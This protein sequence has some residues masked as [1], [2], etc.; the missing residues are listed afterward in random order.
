MGRLEHAAL[1]HRHCVKRLLVSE[2][3][4]PSTLRCLLLSNP[5]P[6]AGDLVSISSAA[7]TAFAL[8]LQ[9][10]DARGSVPRSSPLARPWLSAAGA[11][12]AQGEERSVGQLAAPAQGGCACRELGLM[13]G[14]ART[15]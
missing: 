3:V 15:D 1:F 12:V 8:R 7:E 2:A 4:A 9:S 10:E 11:G 13:H 5:P 6:S 14:L